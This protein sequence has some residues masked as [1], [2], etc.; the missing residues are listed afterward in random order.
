MIFENSR[1]FLGNWPQ[2][3][4]IRDLTMNLHHRVTRAQD[5]VEK[6]TALLDNF[7]TVPLF[8]RDERNDTHLVILSD[9][10]QRVNK[11][12]KSTNKKNDF[13]ASLHNAVLISSDCSNFIVHFGGHSIAPKTTSANVANAKVRIG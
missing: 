13:D 8:E 11:R 6:M 12:Y 1:L 4:R 2:I 9:R 10:H 7:A 5:N 3:E